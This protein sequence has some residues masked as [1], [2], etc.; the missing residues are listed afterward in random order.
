MSHMKNRDSN[1]PRREQRQFEA[2]VR[3]DLATKRSIAER[4]ER[5]G[6]L[7]AQRER[8]KLYEA[9]KA[10]Q[11]AVAAGVTTGTAP[12]TAPA[13]SQGSP[14]GKTARKAAQAA[15]KA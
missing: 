4:R 6:T 2:K 15:A 12:Q 5:L 8:H 13:P 14:K 10:S 7:T 1:K 11:P 9:A 3:Q